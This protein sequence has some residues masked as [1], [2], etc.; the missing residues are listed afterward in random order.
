LLNIS[1]TVV[2]KAEHMLPKEYVTTVLDQWLSV[3]CVVNE[4]K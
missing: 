2:P 1:V 3:N 4:T